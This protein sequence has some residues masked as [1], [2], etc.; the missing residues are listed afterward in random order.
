MDREIETDR[1][2][3]RSESG[4]EYT[5]IE[6][7]KMISFAHYQDLGAEKPGMK[8]L[9]TLDGSPVTYIDSETF[10]IVGTDEI[11]RKIR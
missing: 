8:R 4:E 1:F 5:I 6:Y 11:V 9:V 3:V 10:K 7:Q 2:R